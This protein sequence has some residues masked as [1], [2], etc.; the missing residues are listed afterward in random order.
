MGET[1]KYTATIKISETPQHVAKALKTTDKTD[2]K[3]AMAT[4]QEGTTTIIQFTA[5]N[6]PALRAALNAKMQSITIAEQA[7]EQTI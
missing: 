5:R 4:T 1:M 3:S 2:E 6:A 7:E